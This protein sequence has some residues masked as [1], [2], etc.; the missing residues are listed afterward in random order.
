MV[1]SKWRGQ[2]GK[3]MVS[4]F[5]AKTARSKLLVMRLVALFSQARNRLMAITE[6]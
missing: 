2:Y 1:K 4:D 3:A 5:P 6:K